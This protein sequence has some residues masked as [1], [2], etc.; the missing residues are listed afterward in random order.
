MVKPGKEG[1]KE[2]KKKESEQSLPEHLEI[3]KTHVICG[4]ERNRH[5]RAWAAWHRMY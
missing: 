5:V 3:Q 1:K 2:S 4:T